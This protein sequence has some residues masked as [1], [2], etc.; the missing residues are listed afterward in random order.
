MLTLHFASLRIC[1]SKTPI[2]KNGNI[3]RGKRPKVPMIEQ[4]EAIDY[5]QER[6]NTHFGYLFQ[7][8]KKCQLQPI[9]FVL[10]I[11]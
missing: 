8:H 2:G 11:Q 10:P 6:N 9:A 5:L 3:V 4:R 7:Q 1:N